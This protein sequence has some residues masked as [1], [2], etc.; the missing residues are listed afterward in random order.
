MSRNLVRYNPPPEQYLQRC[1][2]MW[3]R[4][5]ATGGVSLA[6]VPDFNKG[7]ETPED[8]EKACEDAES[9]LLKHKL[10][11]EETRFFTEDYSSKLDVLET[12][13][14]TLM[15]ELLDE[16][17]APHLRLEYSNVI[18]FYM[19]AREMFTFISTFTENEHWVMPCD[20]VDKFI[21]YFETVRL[22]KKYSFVD[23]RNFLEVLEFS[24]EILMCIQT[25][26]R[27]KKKFIKNEEP[28]FPREDCERY[29]SYDYEWFCGSVISGPYHMDCCRWL[30]VSRHAQM[31]LTT[32]RCETMAAAH[33]TFFDY[34]MNIPVPF[35][36][37]ADSPKLILSA[38]SSREACFR[39][40]N[41]R[42]LATL[43]ELIE[44]DPELKYTRDTSNFVNLRGDIRRKKRNVADLLVRSERN[45][46]LPFYLIISVL[47]RVEA[48]L[49]LLHRAYAP[50]M[51]KNIG[52]YGKS[53]PKTVFE[54]AFRIFVITN[55]ETCS[56]LPLNPEI[57]GLLK[58]LNAETRIHI[59]RFYE[60][61]E[62]ECEKF[63]TEPV[64]VD[65]ENDTN[66]FPY[67]VDVD[68]FPEDLAD[69]V[70]PMITHLYWEQY[71]LDR[72][73]EDYAFVKQGYFDWPKAAGT[74]PFTINK[75]RPAIHA[76]DCN[77]SQ[78]YSQNICERVQKSHCIKAINRIASDA[79]WGNEIIKSCEQA[80]E[81]AKCVPSISEINQEFAN[82]F[83]A[84]IGEKVL[85]GMDVVEVTNMIGEIVHSHISASTLRAKYPSPKGEIGTAQTAKNIAKEVLQTFLDYV[86]TQEA[87]VAKKLSAPKTKMEAVGVARAAQKSI[88]DRLDLLHRQ[89]VA[90]ATGTQLPENVSSESSSEEA[91][92]SQASD[93]GFDDDD[94]FYPVPDPTLDLF[95][96]ALNQA[97][98]SHKEFGEIMA[99]GMFG[100]EV[101]PEMVNAFLA[102]VIKVT[103]CWASF[104][105]SDMTNPIYNVPLD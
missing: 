71:E 89:L 59:Q 83:K 27:I 26:Y 25:H 100:S 8:M 91:T 21:E 47:S 96:D 42:S 11:S 57:E 88:I 102:R 72:L 85:D 53:M 2:R 17:P 98:L 69:F 46:C 1:T 62:E 65:L 87:M 14:E 4:D 24:N 35:P 33:G 70:T 103:Y 50:F 31:N 23:L 76:F 97:P 75:H 73:N 56:K 16:V 81:E 3:A 84:A 86:K 15:T 28:S 54:I 45:N 19:T 78:V 77:F 9:I 34:L 82:T 93:N 44:G 74:A 104:D 5:R 51:D 18:A 55:A 39:D 22:I 60:D 12:T 37:S 94:T 101:P 52:L 20:L 68:D 64:P 67:Q 99:S 58:Q 13:F 30:C 48:Q 80:I 7:I 43:K 79:F 32:F 66:Q 63:Y 38:L 36:G 49:L 61:Y 105:I 10:F 29:Y 41:M 6:F 92:S 90:Q 40:A 95:F